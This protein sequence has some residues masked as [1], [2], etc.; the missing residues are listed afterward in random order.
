M[1]QS[2][3]GLLVGVYESINIDIGYDYHDTSP[4]NLFSYTVFTDDS[5]LKGTFDTVFSQA[6]L[7]M[8]VFVL[9]AYV[10]VMMIFI[11]KIYTAMFKPDSRDSE[12]IW[13]MTGKL[14]ISIFLITWSYSIFVYVEKI[15]QV[16]YEQV[17]DV[18]LTAAGTAKESFMS[19]F[20]SIQLGA[21]STM[22]RQDEITD[23]IAYSTG[24]TGLVTMILTIGFFAT[25]IWQYCRLLLEI[26]E[27]YVLLGVMFYTCPLAFSATVS[28]STKHIFR[29]W[30]QMLFTQFLLM[31]MNMFFIGT[32]VAAL[33]NV[34]CMEGREYVF[35]SLGDFVIKNF[36]LIAWLMIGQRLDQYLNA[37]GFSVMQAGSNLGSA[38]ITTA[39][40]S[41]KAAKTFGAVLGATKDFGKAFYAAGH[42][43]STQMQAGK[44]GKDD[45]KN[46]ITEAGSAVNTAKVENLSGRDVN[47]GKLTKEGVQEAMQVGATLTGEDARSAAEAMNLPQAGSKESADIDWNNSQINREGATFI[48]KSDPGVVSSHVAFGNEWVAKDQDGNALAQMAVPTTTGFANGTRVMTDQDLTCANAEVLDQLTNPASGMPNATWTTPEGNPITDASGNYTKEA[49]GS[50]HFVGT[51]MKDP[52]QQYVAGLNN[53]NSFDIDQGGRVSTRNTTAHGDVPSFEYSVQ[54]IDKGCTPAVASSKPVLDTSA[55]S[56]YRQSD[57]VLQKKEPVPMPVE[58]REMRKQTIDN[59]KSIRSRK[60]RHH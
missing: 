13:K 25:I 37:M 50:S 12:N 34:Y 2:L 24:I 53:V 20:L 27:R 5:K 22:F 6:H 52:T 8:Q 42:G 35:A 41:Y 1:V 36:M 46:A 23:V 3:M 30:C 10:I 39:A 26:I 16:I 21:G 44:S 4:D 7:F 31:M 38:L 58:P 51:D 15:A 45:V 11:Y 9:M 28:D 49:L 47:T 60:K 33:D 18:Y 54:H 19:N 43:L 56:T 48:S 32:F 29:S 59:F 40:A 57:V 14:L 55:A 17:F